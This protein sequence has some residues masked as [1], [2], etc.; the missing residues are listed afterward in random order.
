MKEETY[1]LISILLGIL[2][3]VLAVLALAAY[4]GYIPA[5]YVDNFTFGELGSFA[6]L[7]VIGAVGVDYLAEKA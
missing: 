3:S 7:A 4:W 2:A 6:A 5:S 1:R